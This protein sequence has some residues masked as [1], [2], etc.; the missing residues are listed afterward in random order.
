MAAE[1]GYVIKNEIGFPIK[2]L[3]M[4]P[5]I[6]V[7]YG[8]V[9]GPSDEFN[10]GKALAGAYVGVKG[11]VSNLSYDAFIGTPIYKPDGFK[12]GKTACGFNLYWEF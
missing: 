2:N 5:Y 6:G 8:R 12:A 4:E 11:K 7:D 10:L 3:N 9:W 1:N